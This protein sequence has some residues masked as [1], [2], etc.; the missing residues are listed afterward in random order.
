MKLQLI[1]LQ[2]KEIIQT[3]KL[4]ELETELKIRDN[5]I[6][7]SN[8]EMSGLKDE[9]T[10]LKVTIMHQHIHAHSFSPFLLPFSFFLDRDRE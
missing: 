3:T 6:R 7:K 2:Q 10:K 5:C 9:I 1:Q 4:S 8:D